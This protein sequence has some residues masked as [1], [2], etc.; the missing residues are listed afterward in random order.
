MDH[1]DD[2]LAGALYQLANEAEQLS[3]RIRAQ[4]VVLRHAHER[5][6]SQRPLTQS[7]MQ[8]AHPVRFVLDDDMTIG[9]P[10]HPDL[11]LETATAHEPK[12]EVCGGAKSQCMGVHSEGSRWPTC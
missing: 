4:S 11:S 7:V 8:H 2:G 9:Q 3:R 12:C 6:E 5:A 1:D 10:G